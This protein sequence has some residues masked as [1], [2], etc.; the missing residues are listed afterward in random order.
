MYAFVIDQSETRYFVEYI[1]RREIKQRMNFT[2]S[3]RI[4][5]RLSREY[6][7]AKSDKKEFVERLADEA[8][9]A[10]SRQDLKSV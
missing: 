2:R 8:E 5:D 7:N 3:E 4:H 10:A 9:K 6:S 1:I